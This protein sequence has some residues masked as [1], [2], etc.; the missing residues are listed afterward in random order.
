MAD[1]ISKQD[2]RNF[3]ENYCEHRTD[4]NE[5]RIDGPACPAEGIAL[6]ECPKG[7]DDIYLD[8]VFDGI[9]ELIKEDIRKKKF[10]V[11]MEKQ[12]EEEQARATAFYEALP[13]ILKVFVD[14][15]EDLT[16]LF[17][18]DQLASFLRVYTALKTLMKEMGE[19][20]QAMEI[21]RKLKRGS[22]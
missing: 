8:S 17:R 10:Q 20:E 4:C 14:N 16:N 22:K 7:I 19:A 13:G 6:I 2:K 11:Q 15:S 18:E 9:Q 1:V 12:M 5:N 21:L 3:I